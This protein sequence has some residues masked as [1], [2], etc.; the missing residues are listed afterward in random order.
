MEVKC[1]VLVYFRHVNDE[2]GSDLSS[3]AQYPVISL[4]F[5]YDDDPALVGED[6]QKLMRF[7]ISFAQW[8]LEVKGKIM[9]LN[10]NIT[11][12]DAPSF[13]VTANN[14]IGVSMCGSGTEFVEFQ[15]RWEKVRLDFKE[16]F[17]NHDFDLND[18]FEEIHALY[19][20]ISDARF[21]GR[22]Q[23]VRDRNGDITICQH[24]FTPLNLTDES[25]RLFL[26]YLNSLY[27]LTIK[28]EADYRYSMA[29]GN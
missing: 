11:D 8:L 26:E 21:V 13:F 29:K 28:G 14:I 20:A 4:E 2:A 23:I 16:L 7:S 17:D 6:S 18:D 25:R 19:H 5:P 22:F 9:D 12:I 1:K 3:V 15:L 27:E 24:G 10:P